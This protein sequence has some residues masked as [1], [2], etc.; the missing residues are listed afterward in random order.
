MSDDKKLMANIPPFGLRMQPDL[1]ARV[2]AVARL[3][4]RSLNAEIVARLEKSLED[5]DSLAE[6]WT[7]VEELERMVWS[8]DEQLS[9]SKHYD[10]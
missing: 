8:H 1:K 4:N 5:D 10:D 3:N 7:K 9:P 2:E 6:L